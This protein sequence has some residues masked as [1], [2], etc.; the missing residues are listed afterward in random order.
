[1]TPHPPI[2][3]TSHTYTVGRS[4]G[5][6]YPRDFPPAPTAIHLAALYD[7]AAQRIARLE[8]ALRQLNPNHPDLKP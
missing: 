6:V 4:E 1:M 7:A 5:V 3:S 8:A 2:S